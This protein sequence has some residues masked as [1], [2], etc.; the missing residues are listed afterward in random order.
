MTVKDVEALRAQYRESYRRKTAARRAKGLCVKCGKRP[1]EPGRT[2]CEPCAEKQRAADLERYHRR[3]AERV[4]AGMCPKC[5]KRPPA[6]ERS[7]CEPCLEKDAAA[8]RARDARLRAAG[9]PR[10]DPVKTREYERER[11]RRQTGARRAEG[12]CTACGKTQAVPGRAFCGPCLEKRRAWDRAKYAAGKAAGK[13]YGGADPEARRRAARARGARRRKAWREAGLCHRCGRVPPEEGRAKCEPCR[14]DRRA[15][16]R[17]RH[18][19]R[20]DAG[21]C[22]DCATPAPGGKAYCGPCAVTRSRRRNL[23]AKREASRRRYAERR[24][25]GDCT[26]CGKPAHGPAECQACCD[27][28][29]ARYD[30]RRAAGVCVKCRT[31]TRGG[32]AYC[33]P[34]AVAKAGQRDRGAEYAAK[35]RRY[36]ERRARGCCVECGA[37]SP[38]VARCEPCSRKHRESSGAFRGIPLWDPT[39][40]V[41]EIAT[42]EELGTYDSEADVTLCLAFAK[43]SRDEVEVLCDASPM[44]S[45]TA[46]P[47]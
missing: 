36:A 45:Y 44:S 30:A 22:V 38:G 46:P 37:P 8:G 7:Q 28:A 33:A 3:T 1:P 9:V 6:P 26:S 42:G 41:I 16:N 19:E 17:A 39:W 40:T 25:R 32:T 31:P 11:T 47:W 20:R 27:A 34:C 24:A 2:R 15:A 13:P 12:L 29:R 10:R 14:E 4:A 23:K 21:L 35:R 18:A 5:G 43:L